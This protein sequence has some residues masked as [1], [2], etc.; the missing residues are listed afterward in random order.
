MRNKDFTVV[1][2]YVVITGAGGG[3]GLS[4]VQAFLE[5]RAIVIAIARRANMGWQGLD[6]AYPDTLLHELCDLSDEK[7]VKKLGDMLNEK[8]PAI[9]VLINNACPNNIGTK[10]AYDIS[11]FETIRKIGLDAP[12]ILCGKIAPL[13]AERKKGSIINITSINA[14]SAWPNNPAYVTVKSGLKMLTK[15]IA[16]DFGLNGVRANNVSPGYVHTRMTNQS[17]TDEN[18]YQ[19]RCNRTMLGRWG[20][21]EEIAN[22]CLFLASDASSYI[23]GTDI[24][25]DGGWLAKGL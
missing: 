20:K 5:E 25:V 4:L 8:Y 3:I 1:G 24:I 14:E 16:R 18:A 11:A 9:D 10:D 19:E 22:T 17:F 15:A 12:Y 2:K 6:I 7:A 23:T 13:M 21:P